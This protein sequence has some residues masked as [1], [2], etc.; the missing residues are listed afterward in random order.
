MDRLSALI[1]DEC[2]AMPNFGAV[3]REMRSSR[4]Y[5]QQEVALRINRGVT[6]ISDAENGRLPRATTI[7]DILTLAKAL[8]CHPSQEARLID[9]FICHVLNNLLG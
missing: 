7:S 2:G 8:D 6:W 1:D 9:A 4:N 3:L 5:S